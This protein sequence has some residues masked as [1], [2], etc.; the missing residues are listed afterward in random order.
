MFPIN[1]IYQFKQWNILEDAISVDFLRIIFVIFLL[2]IVLFLPSNLEINDYSNLIEDKKGTQLIS[3]VKTL[4]NFY[5]YL[6][7]IILAT[8]FMFCIFNL[9]TEQAF[10]YFQF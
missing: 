9:K 4:N 3:K 8:I 10:I 7:S 6:F 2:F 5:L 1:K